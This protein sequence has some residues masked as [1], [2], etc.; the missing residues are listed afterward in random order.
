MWSDA[1]R[2]AALE[3]RRRSRAR[4]QAIV[5]VINRHGVTLTTTRRALASEMIALRGLARKSGIQA[6]LRK[7][8][9]DSLVRR[10]QAARVSTK[11]L[12]G[13]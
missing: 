6:D 3:M 7:S 8:Y 13:T 4:G 5:H 12:K 9:L 11:S 1:A 2:A 10:R